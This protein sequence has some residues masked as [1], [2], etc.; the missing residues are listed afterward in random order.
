MKNPLIQCVDIKAQVEDL[1]P[2]IQMEMGTHA[3][4]DKDSLKGLVHFFCGFNLYWFP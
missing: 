4:P 3:S 1:F 2:G